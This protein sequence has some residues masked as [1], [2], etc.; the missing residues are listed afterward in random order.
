MKAGVSDRIAGSVMAKLTDIGRN[1]LGEVDA[2]KVIPRQSET[3]QP[4]VA[5]SIYAPVIT[6]RAIDHWSAVVTGSANTV[7]RLNGTSR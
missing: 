4:T 5:G 6:L 7:L 3:P 2:F 1:V